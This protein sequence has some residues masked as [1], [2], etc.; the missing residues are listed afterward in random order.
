MSEKNFSIPEAFSTEQA[1]LAKELVHDLK[2]QLAAKPKRLKHSLGVAQ[3][4]YD[5]A[6]VYDVDPFDAY[7]AGL[8]HD[9]DKAVPMP[10]LIERAR[11]FDID[12]GVEYSL[13]EPLLHG[14]V[15]AKEL[16]ALYPW[17]SSEILYAISVHTTGAAQMSALDMVLFVADG[18][19][20]GRKAVPAIENLRKHVGKV[21]LT[22]L[23]WESFS[24]GIVYVIETNRYLWPGTI[25]IY[26]SWVGRAGAQE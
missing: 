25:D 21:G 13:V 4:A 17:L 8:L 14:M 2:E 1:A 15:A 23:F 7:V 10:E 6:L 24:G 16:P 9:W 11:G 20:P 18:I 22:Q 19:E 3:T 26:N 5:L 12:L